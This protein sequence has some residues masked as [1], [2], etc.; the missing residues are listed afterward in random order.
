M[1]NREMYSRLRRRHV[2]AALVVALTIVGSVIG[3]RALDWADDPDAMRLF[4]DNNR[5][6]AGIV[7]A[8]VLEATAE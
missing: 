1:S 5:D 2:V 7:I 8:E 6:A 4:V 3:N